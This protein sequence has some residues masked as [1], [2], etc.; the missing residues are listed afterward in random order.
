MTGPRP[1]AGLLCGVCRHRLGTDELATCRACVA[2]VRAHLG[3][4]EAAYGLLP[5]LLPA[6]GSNAPQDGRGRAAERPIP[7]GDALV[8]LGPG[9]P[10]T[11]RL[12]AFLAGDDP[13]WDQ[14]DR[15]SDPPSA[16]YE[17]GRWVDDWLLLRREPAAAVPLPVPAAV[18]FLRD[19]LQW[20]ASR[21]PGFGEF[22]LDVKVLRACLERAA[23]LDEPVERAGVPCFDCGGDLERGYDHNGRADDWRCRRCH[24]VYDSASYLLAVRA[25]LEEVE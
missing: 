6:C 20:A 23:G 2:D 1:D 7:G 4:I 8:L 17:L 9:S 14:D 25:Q 13:D 11:A 22:V 10:A 19:R 5:L 15:R 21:H 3:A 24:R 12:R 18:A 16:R